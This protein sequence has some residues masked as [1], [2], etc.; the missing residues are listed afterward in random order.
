M[1]QNQ[2]G[3]ARRSRQNDKN[4]EK[5]KRKYEAPPP[6]HVGKRKKHAKG[7]DAA[8]KLPQITPHTRCR[9][10]LLKLERIKDY[11]LMEEEFLKNMERLKPQD[12]KH[13]EERSKV[14]QFCTVI[15]TPFSRISP[16]T[17]AFH[18]FRWTT[19]V[20]RQWQ[21]AVWKRLL[22]INTPLC[23]HRS[24]QSTTFLS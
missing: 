18:W 17:C 20:D 16:L 14:S 11:L 2:S 9:L 13:E 1:G 22:T 6:T 10:R 12:E 23:L 8:S 7:P 21:S 24:V 15:Q 5:Q 3:G 4:G 19:Y